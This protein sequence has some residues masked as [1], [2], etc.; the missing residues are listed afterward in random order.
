MLGHSASR[1]GRS[2][3]HLEDRVII[4]DDNPDLLSALAYMLR[5]DGIEVET[6]ADGL[7]ALQ[8]CRRMRPGVVVLDLYMPHMS[9][10][11][12]LDALRKDSDLSNVYAIM[13]SGM[14]GERS[15]LASLAPKADQHLIKP[16]DADLLVATIEQGLQRRERR[17]GLLGRL[18][19]R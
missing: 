16:V 1:S 3:M 17:A 12:V 18:E 11:E 8:L 5:S 14:A 6:A 13:L 10:L 4:A 9:G 2:G 7:S 15:E 19:R